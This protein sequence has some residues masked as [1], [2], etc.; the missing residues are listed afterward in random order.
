MTDAIKVSQGM[1][2]KDDWMSERA[3]MYVEDLTREGII[4]L[5]FFD[6]LKTTR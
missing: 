2:G 6:K 4:L 3:V 1:K 5:T